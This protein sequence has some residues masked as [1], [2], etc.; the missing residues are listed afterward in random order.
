MFPDYDDTYHDIDYD[1]SEVH[2]VFPQPT[3]P[4]PPPAAPT[5]APKQTF[6]VRPNQ[7]IDGRSIGSQPAYN[8]LYSS[9]AE[10]ER[11]PYV[12]SRNPILGQKN[13]WN[14]AQLINEMQTIHIM[15]FFIMLIIIVYLHTKLSKMEYAIQIL[16]MRQSSLMNAKV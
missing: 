16:L 2:T 11:E 12:G 5:A 4:A 6:D 13:K 15:I 14:C 8:L 7:V 1:Y 9:G 10:R 3:V